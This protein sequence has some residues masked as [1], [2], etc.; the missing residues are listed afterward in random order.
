MSLSKKAIRWMRWKPC[1][2]NVVKLGWEFA[3][4]TIKISVKTGLKCLILN[5]VRKC[6]C[7]TEQPVQRTAFTSGRRLL[8]MPSTV[9]ICFSIYC[10][11][12]S[13][14]RYVYDEGIQG[15]FTGGM[16][17]LTCAEYLS[18]YFLMCFIKYRRNLIIGNTSL[19]RS[20]D[21]RS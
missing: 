15:D 4:G 8:S 14:Q 3:S 7:E 1:F 11:Q 19:E 18:H 6:R 10:C 2:V 12:C 16:R 17:E 20:V 5:T 21:N 9:Y 13:H